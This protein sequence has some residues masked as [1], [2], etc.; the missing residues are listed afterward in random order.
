MK[1]T[2]QLLKEKREAANLS[3]SEV[4][5][6]TKINPKVLTAMENGDEAGLPSK[7]F[8]KG[9]LRAYAVF[10]KMNPEEVLRSYQEESGQPVV[11]V[12]RAPEVENPAAAPAAKG[13]RRPM[14]DG[15]NAG[16]RTAAVVVIVILIGVIILV[17]EKFEQYQR[18]KQVE[19]SAI[20]VSPLAQPGIVPE[21]TKAG[22]STA[23]A[24]PSP[25]GTAD[26]VPAN[27]ATIPAPDM[28]VKPAPAPTPA[29][30]AAV[31]KE[32]PPEKEKPAAETKGLPPPP[33][34]PAAAATPATLPP[35]PAPV[36]APEKK[37]ET[38]KAETPK[39]ELKKDDSA[40]AAK[41]VGRYEVILE[42]LDK[43]EIKFDIKGETKKISLG[44]NQ[45]H[46]IHADQPLT[47][48]ISDGGAVSVILNGR[49]R[50]VPGDLGKPKTIKLP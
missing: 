25:T 2:G 12:K 7:T 46:T 21:G 22:E 28:N 24:T 13:P 5:L 3:L 42:A 49:E 27:P 45:V 9:F 30:A 18:E 48:D 14:K 41:K 35:P 23:A 20:K 33:P 31:E 1:K 34:N 8:L 11:E 29:P 32:K 4:A 36:P 44:P 15:D 40:A 26:T 50:G 19:A 17:K 47:L 43:V 39:E 6:A 16:L 10:L 37:A 38:P